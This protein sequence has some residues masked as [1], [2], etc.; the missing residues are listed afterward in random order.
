MTSIDQQTE[1]RNTE[2]KANE[3]KKR[4]LGDFEELKVLGQ[5]SFGIVKLVK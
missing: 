5:G 1:S 3:S 2:G 4:A